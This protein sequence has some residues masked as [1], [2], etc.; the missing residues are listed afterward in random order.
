MSDRM[1]VLFIITDQ[2]RS[3]HMS[4]AGNTTLKTP[5]LDKLAS[6]G[7]RFTSAYVAN[8]ICMPNRAS[9]FTGLYPNMHG[10]R[11]AGMNLPEEVPTFTETLLNNGYHTIAIGKIHLQFSTRRLV[12]SARS[13]ESAG[14]W[15]SEK[16]HD[17]MKEN[18]PLP[19]YGFK[20]VNLVVGHGDI[21]SGHY[22]DWLEEK[23][24]E[25][26]PIIR[27]KSKGF[28]G[29]MSY[30]TEIPEELFPTSYINEQAINFLEE[31]SNGKY[32]DNPFFL[33]VSYPDPHH[34]VCP[35]GKYYDMYKPKD[36]KL[37]QSFK[38][39][40]N[41]KKHPFL[42]K[43]LDNPFVRG[44]ILRITN[45]EEAKDFIAA[46]YGS[47]VMIDNSIGQILTALEKFGLSDNTMVIYTSDHGDL[48]GDH[49]M[50]LKG[51]CPFN[52]ILNVP[53]IWKVPGVTKP[54][55]TDSLASSIDISKTILNL[56]N[57]PKETQPPDMQ[58]DD[59]TPI[60]TDPS[61]KVRDFCLVEHDEEIEQ[62]KLKIRLRHLITDEYK[63]TIYNRLPGYGDL[64][65]RK[66]DPNE[67]HNLWFDEN[68]KEIRHTLVEK[69]LHENLNAQ[70]RYPKRLAMS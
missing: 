22:F 1:N 62:F 24:P 60:L 54:A 70:S 43:N 51:P 16:Y 20:E 36:I 63:L 11:T 7:V 25:Y 27:E 57:I 6:E 18:L 50:I 8:P 33:N 15:L 3:D 31:Y 65:N 64:F 12:D 67:L 29:K 40:D 39:I 56:L 37:P 38:D 45:E 4:C 2:H 59:L 19:Y 23:S 49:G 47:V 13:A 5:N 26:L 68:Y 52:G 10:V 48:M 69:L 58:G 44:M 53:F 42:G 34:P 30:R 41:V 35:P 9:I 28:F 66:K 32:G 55:I 21:C 61:E 46:T 14:H 17:K